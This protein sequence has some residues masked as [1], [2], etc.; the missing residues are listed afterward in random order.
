MTTT[1]VFNP[2]SLATIGDRLVY[3][4][5]TL[6]AT[7]HFVDSGLPNELARVVHD[8]AQALL[9]DG[10]EPNWNYAVHRACQLTAQEINWRKP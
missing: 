6:T 9:D 3:W 5:G 4:M 2:A 8:T 7:R 1:H 10:S